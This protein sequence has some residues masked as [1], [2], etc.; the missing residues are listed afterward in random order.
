V[1]DEQLDERVSVLEDKV[2]FLLKGRPG[3]RY[4]PVTVSEK[5]VCG[6]DP[7]RDSATCEDASLWRKSK[8]CRGT[9]CTTK[10]T[11]YFANYRAARKVGMTPDSAYV[12]DP[13]E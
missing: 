7:T 1:S 11:E 3:R 12:E 2:D 13:D 5:G 6:V 9:A 4:L 8:G 10:A